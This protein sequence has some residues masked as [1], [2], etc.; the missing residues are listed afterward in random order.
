MEMRAVIDGL[1]QILGGQ[2][3]GP[4][5]AVPEP[6]SAVVAQVRDMS[7]CFVISGIG[8]L[9]AAY[10]IGQLAG[11]GLLTAARCRG[12]LSL[13][14]AG[15]YAR[16]VAPVGS[17]VM[18]TKETWPEYGLFTEAGIDAKALGFPLMGTKDD[19][20]P[21]WDSLALA[22][23]EAL[24]AMGL[25]EPSSM[26]RTGKNPLVALGPSITVAAVSGSLSRAGELAARH[27]ALIE[28][29]EGF[30]LALAA[31]RAGIPFAEL[32]SVSNIVGDRRPE[33]WNV[34]ASL[35]ALSRAVGL[36]FTR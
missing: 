1:G 32:R 3:L 9:A 30:P 25:K 5:V 28:N 35:A 26:P 15:T 7:L 16:D 29:M 2:D 8:P 31:L 14:I 24:V 4:D 27:A 36:L 21:V 13:G 6:G 12:L 33:A 22:P 34:P 20:D 10:S 18:A 17:L 11:E 23:S 19:P